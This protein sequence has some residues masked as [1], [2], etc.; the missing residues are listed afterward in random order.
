MEL[1]FKE[2][3]ISLFFGRFNSSSYIFFKFRY[4]CQHERKVVE[5]VR[6]LLKG[7]QKI[8]HQPLE[9]GEAMLHRYEY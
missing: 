3:K 9:S 4:S 6:I 7:F 8:G 2:Y 1:L 5:G